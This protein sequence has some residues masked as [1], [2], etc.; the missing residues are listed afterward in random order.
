MVNGVAANLP[1]SRKAVDIAYREGSDWNV[2]TPLI[3]QWFADLK[4]WEGIDTFNAAFQDKRMT[5]RQVN[6]D[7]VTARGGAFDVGGR[8]MTLARDVPGIKARMVPTNYFHPHTVRPRKNELGLH[9]LRTSLLTDARPIKTQLKGYENV[10]AL[11]VPL[12]TEDDLYLFDSLNQTAKKEPAG[13]VLMKTLRSQLTRVKLAQASDMGSTFQNAPLPGQP[14]RFRYGLDGTII[15]ENQRGRA[16]KIGAPATAEELFNRKTNALRYKSILVNPVTTVNE[17]A[18]AYR[19]HASPLFPM[20][21][22]WNQAAQHFRVYDT[23]TM[24]PIAVAIT[25]QGVYGPAPL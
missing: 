15:G 23:N 19:Q 18:L 13:A 4:A 25:N 17:I 2:L 1:E 10:L 11:F 5:C 21:T 6:I 22:Q 20:F 3:E 8:Q 9:D 16:V 12:P 14:E 7:P 24:T